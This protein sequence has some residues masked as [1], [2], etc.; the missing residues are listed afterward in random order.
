MGTPPK[1]PGS[2]SYSEIRVQLV[3]KI[4]E[5]TR[6]KKIAWRSTNDGVTASV[7]GKMELNFLKGR[8]PWFI[9]PPPEQDW[10][11]FTARDEK[12]DEILSIENSSG[13]LGPAL[14]SGNPLLIAVTELYEA[15]LDLGKEDI[16]RAINIIDEA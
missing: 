13:S 11:V 14:Y 4:T 16:E 9:A 3:H 12:G 10:V 1:Q 2:S 6:R 8:G 7:S 15:I 5:K